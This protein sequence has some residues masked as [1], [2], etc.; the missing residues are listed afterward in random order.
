MTYTNLKVP[1][2]RPFDVNLSLPTSIKSAHFLEN[3][4]TVQRSC[5]SHSDIRRPDCIDE[6]KPCDCAQAP[7]GTP[8]AHICLLGAF[9]LS[10]QCLPNLECYIGIPSMHLE[11]WGSAMPGVVSVAVCMTVKFS[12]FINPAQG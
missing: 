4:R 9:D 8:T 7:R 2:T 3:K 1:Q 10:R 12:C 11:L 6:W 5:L